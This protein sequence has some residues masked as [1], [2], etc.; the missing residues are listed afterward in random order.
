M[1]LKGTE[2][3]IDKNISKS[4][5]NNYIDEIIYFFEAT[6]TMSLSSRT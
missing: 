5:L 1:N 2:I 6:N 3:E 4:I